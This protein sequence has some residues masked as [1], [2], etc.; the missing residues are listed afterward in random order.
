MILEEGAGIIMKTR[1]ILVRHGETHKNVAKVLHG[2]KDDA[3]LN[4]LGKSQAGRAAKVLV[5]MGVDIIYSSTELRASQTAEII[6]R[7]CKV[8]LIYLDDFRERDWGIFEGQ[9]WGEVESVLGQM[10]LPERYKFK[11]ERGESWQE[12]ETRL[13]GALKLIISENEG[14]TVAIVTHG[15]TIRT[16]IPYLLNTSLEESFKYDPRH[17]SFTIF[18][19]NGKKFSKVFIDDTSHLTRE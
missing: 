8:P 19:F 9:S 11:P 2:R 16:L 17:L 6:N 12:V 15:G 1:L 3:S 14:K 5:E 10:Q 18:N 4:E 7:S 13:I